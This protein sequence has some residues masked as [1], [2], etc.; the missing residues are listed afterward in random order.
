VKRLNRYFSLF[1]VALFLLAPPHTHGRK[2]PPPARALKAG[3]ATGAGSAAASVSG[4]QQRRPQSASAP[5]EL[6]RWER[7]ARNVTIVRDDWGI[8]HI[9]GHRDADAV[10]GLLYAQAEDDFNRVEMNYLN[11]LGRMAEAEGE[12]AVYQDLRMRLFTDEES[13]RAQYAASPR[14]LKALMNAM[15]DGLNYYLYKHP[16]VK[17]KVITHFEPWM[18]LSFTEGSIGWDLETID[19][20]Q[21]EAFYRSDRR[22]LV[23][24]VD[25]GAAEARE[26]NGEPGG[27]NGFAIAPSNT[28]GHR[29]LLLINPHTSFFFRAEVQAS[30][31]E[32]LNVYGAVTWGQFFV[33]Q[34]FNDRAGWMHTSSAADDMDEYLETVNRKGNRLYY[35]YGVG[36]RPVTI[37]RVNVAYRTEAGMTNKEFTVYRTHHGP[38]VREVGGKW[39]GERA[40]DARPGESAH[41]VVP[42]DEGQKLQGVSSGHGTAHQLLEQHYLRGRRRPNRVLPRQLHPTARPAL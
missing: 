5:N 19:L 23:S 42:A 26:L 40:S 27:S 22:R 7:Q 41:A 3:A 31:D 11:A 13:L 32:G 35:R 28:E 9:H 30:S 29:A 12:R 34:G 25:E 24:L 15:A 2:A 36:G 33:Y 6:T 4:A 14:W 17:P 18:A 20:K 1:F 21:L 38:V 39:V 10:F 16:E 37:S 8:P